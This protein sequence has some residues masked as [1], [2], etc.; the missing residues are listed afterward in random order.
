MF[1]LLYIA[2][3]QYKV[4]EGVALRCMSNLYEMTEPIPT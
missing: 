3:M 4:L 2:K 1:D